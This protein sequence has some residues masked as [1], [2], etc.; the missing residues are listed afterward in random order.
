MYYPKYKS[1]SSLMEVCEGGEGW[2]GCTYVCVCWGMGGWMCVY[3]HTNPFILH[4]TSS[5]LPALLQA[6]RPDT[7]RG[8]VQTEAGPRQSEAHTQHPLQ[9]YVHTYSLCVSLPVSVTCQLVMSLNVVMYSILSFCHLTMSHCTATYMPVTQLCGRASDMSCCRTVNNCQI[10]VCTCHLVSCVLHV[11]S[12]SS[13]ATCTDPAPSPPLPQNS[14]S[15]VLN[16]LAAVYWRVM[17]NGEMAV[18]CL[19]VALQHSPAKCRVS[20]GV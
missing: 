15:W 12:L 1:E 9:S 11:T 8:R 4:S 3:N 16:D 19:K 6:G 7:G 17:G 5:E 2:G 18:R 14:S 10:T 13:G 20:V